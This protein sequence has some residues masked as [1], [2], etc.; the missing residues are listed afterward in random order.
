MI[1]NPARMLAPFL[2]CGATNSFELRRP[3]FDSQ[4]QEPEENG[5]WQ[6]HKCR[7]RS[8]AAC[9]AGT[10]AMNRRSLL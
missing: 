2:R 8:V 5:R 6:T 9:I 1:T 4:L 10:R 7:R 3:Q